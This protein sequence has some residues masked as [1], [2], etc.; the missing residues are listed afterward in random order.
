MLTLIIL[1]LFISMSF[2]AI[3]PF[4]STLPHVSVVGPGSDAGLDVIFG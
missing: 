4:I 3:L 1:K 2:D